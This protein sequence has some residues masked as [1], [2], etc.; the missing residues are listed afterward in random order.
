MQQRHNKVYVLYT[1]P[2]GCTPDP[3]TGEFPT[4]GQLSL[5]T[6]TA[7]ETKILSPA[8]VNPPQTWCFY[9]PSH[10]IG[11][12]AFGNNGEIY[13]S[14]GDGAS[15]DQ[16]DYGQLDT[17]CGDPGSGS[18]FRS[19]GSLPDGI[20]PPPYTSSPYRDGVILRIAAPI[21]PN[22]SVTVVAYGF[23]N[24]FRFAR[25]PGTNDLY[26][27]NVGWGTWEAIDQISTSTTS[28]NFGWPCYEGPDP[29]PDYQSTGYCGNVGSVTAP[30]FAYNHLR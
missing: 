27:G 12:L 20:H 2:G 11:G 26:V 9:W 29:Q 22:P 8:T 18:A 28:Q 23:R 4:N 6:T 14:A 3:N 17:A 15:F 7:G 16:V 21:T 1:T 25:M 10:S 5:L 13:V 24:P 30:F 19:Q